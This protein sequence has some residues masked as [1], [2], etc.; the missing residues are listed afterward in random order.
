[1]F[2]IVQLVSIIVHSFLSSFPGMIFILL[3]VIII[4]AVGIY[5]YYGGFKKISLQI[6]EEGGETLVYEEVIG[7]YRTFQNSDE[8][9]WLLLRRGSV[10]SRV[11]QGFHIFHLIVVFVLSMGRLSFIHKKPFHAPL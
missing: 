3:A 7:G 10:Y 2:V 1:M 8:E 6:R 5:A 11:H 9:V 4:A